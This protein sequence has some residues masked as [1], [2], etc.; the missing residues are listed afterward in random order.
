MTRENSSPDPAVHIST[1]YSMCEDGPE[2]TED[3][4]GLPSCL[5]SGHRASLNY[6][7]M[8][9]AHSLFQNLGHPQDSLCLEVLSSLS[10]ERLRRL[11]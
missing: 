3:V 2:G 1:G 5:D 6:M 9:A 4:L 11:C 7:N 10:P 8:L